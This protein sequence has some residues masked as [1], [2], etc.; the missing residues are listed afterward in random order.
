MMSWIWLMIWQFGYV[1][2]I[3]NKLNFKSHVSG[4]Y[5]KAGR[6]LNV[7]QRL[8]GS[9]DYASRLSIYKSLIMSN[10]NYCP[11]VWMFTS[12]SSLSK[13]ETMKIRALRFVLDDYAS[14][15]YDLLKTVD[16]PGMKTVA[17]RFLAIGVYKC[18]NGLNPKYLNDLFIVEKCKYDL[19]DDSVI[20]RN[21]AQ[22]TNYGLKSFKDY[23][24]KIW[25]L[26]SDCCKG[27]SLH[28]FK[29]LIKSR[30]GPK[31][32]CSVCLYFIWTGPYL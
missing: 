14:D 28:E 15:Y 29:V 32:S 1:I 12:K 27:L 5:N 19:R 17:L 18:I 23:G 4:M 13:L 7:L 6:Q 21:I 8:K 11:V 16:V 25:N 9:L 10:F 20:N 31:C 26:L 2:N 30:N 22:T 24:A 3:D